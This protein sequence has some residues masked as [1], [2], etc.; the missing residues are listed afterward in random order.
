MGQE[1]SNTLGGREVPS[2]TPS[3]STSTNKRSLFNIA[4]QHD[5]DESE[6]EVC[7]VTEELDQGSDTEQGII[8]VLKGPQDAEE[9]EEL[10]LLRAIKR[11][12]PF[13]K[14]QDKGFSIEHLLGLKSKESKS[15][16]PSKDSPASSDPLLDIFFGLQTHI[17]E[18]MLHINLEQRILLKRIAYVDELS[19]TASQTMSAAFSQAKLA[20]DRVSEVV[21]IK[22]QAEKAH[23]HIIDIFRALTKLEQYLDPQDRILAAEPVDSQWPVLQQLRLKSSKSAETPLLERY[24]SSSSDMTSVGTSTSPLIEKVVVTGESASADEQKDGNDLSKTTPT[25]TSSLALDRL[26]GLSSKSTT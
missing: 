13:I 25:S 16:E 10:R 14:E 18:Q 23:S 9:E 24:I 19:T 5:K 6:V 17:Q 8:E 3:T 1:Q 11:F 15:K 2:L 26:R 22:E 21:A 20:A 12:E 7:S 4:H